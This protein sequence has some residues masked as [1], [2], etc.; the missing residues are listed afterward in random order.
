[1]DTSRLGAMSPAQLSVERER[2]RKGVV[3][4]EPGALMRL[5]EIAAEPA[6]RSARLK[7]TWEERLERRYGPL[8]D[9]R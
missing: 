8:E 5:A 1:M 2:A 7:P 9:P 3:G 4:R 6:R